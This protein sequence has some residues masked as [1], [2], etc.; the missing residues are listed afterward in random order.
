[1]TA[2]TAVLALVFF[3]VAAGFSLLG[4][5]GGVLYT[6]I[7]VFAGIDFHVAATTSL[8]LIMAISLSSTLVFRRAGRVDWPLALSLEA[9][10]AAGG[11]LGGFF[12]DRFSGPTLMLVFT[13]VVG[14]SATFM[15]RKVEHERP[16]PEWSGP[17]SWVREAAGYR[18]CVNMPLALTVS[19]LAGCVS[20]LVGVGGGI[21]KVP[22]MVLLFGIPIE[23]AVASSAFMI[24]LTALGG[25]A[26]H[27]VSGHVGHAHWS[28]TGSLVLGV[29]VFLGAQVGARKSVA[30]DGRKIKPV[31]GWF[32]LGVAALMAVK[33]LSESSASPLLSPG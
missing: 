18:Y 2:L 1:M 33:A 9:A 19:S 30:L 15:I 17:F 13:G 10:T 26:G 27:V 12:S 24:G 4:Q 31:F 29:A 3:L 20:G 25:F 11:F 14:F 6:P 5:G 32:L 23:I 28:W 8:F 22:M 7:Q 16:C 21:L